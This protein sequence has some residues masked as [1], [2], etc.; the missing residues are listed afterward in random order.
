MGIAAV[1]DYG[2]GK[3]LH[4]GGRGRME[5]RHNLVGVPAPEDIYLVIVEASQEEGHGAPARMARALLS[6]GRKTSELPMSAVA[7][8]RAVVISAL[9]I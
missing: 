1:G 4:A 5:I 9:R 3:A 6:L 2:G 7:R 8:R